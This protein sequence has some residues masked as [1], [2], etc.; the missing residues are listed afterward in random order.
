[1]LPAVHSHTVSAAAGGR[2]LMHDMS[3]IY[4]YIYV[5]LQDT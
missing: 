3:Y 1:M 2:N 4:M 5:L